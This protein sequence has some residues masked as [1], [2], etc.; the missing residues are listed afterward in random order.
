MSQTRNVKNKDQNCITLESAK[1]FDNRCPGVMPHVAQTDVKEMK[2]C[3]IVAKMDGCRV[4]SQ[5]GNILKYEERIC[6]TV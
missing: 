4:Q 3:K 1:W 6:I 2:P 5:N